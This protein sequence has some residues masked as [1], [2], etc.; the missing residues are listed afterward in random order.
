MSVSVTIGLKRIDMITVRKAELS[1]VMAIYDTARYYFGGTYSEHHIRTQISSDDYLVLVAET[2]PQETVAYLILMHVLDEAYITSIAVN[3]KYSR[4]G[5][6]SCLIEYIIDE[7]Q[8]MGISFIS[9]EV[10]EH[11]ENAINLYR[12]FGFEHQGNMKNY[13]SCPIEDAI[14]MTLYL[15]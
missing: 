10:R 9:L 15:K 11:N 6:A 14:I 3:E 7:A 2:S 4:Q 8:R 12:K 5:I 13:Y 1:D